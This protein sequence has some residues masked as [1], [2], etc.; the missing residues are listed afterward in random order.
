M[1]QPIAC[2]L[3]ALTADE[4]KRQEALRAE[5]DAAI[6]ERR[7][8]A[9]GYRFIYRAG[10]AVLGAAAEWIAIERR[11]CPFLDFTLTWRADAEGPAL[12]LSGGPGVKAFIGQ[13]FL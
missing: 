8:T 5:L 10:P 6:V 3:D 4:R 12:E 7:E 13:T 9:D 2:R 11:C 1:T